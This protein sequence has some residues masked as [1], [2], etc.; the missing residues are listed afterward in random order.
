M[1]SKKTPLS[2]ISF[3]FF[4]LLFSLSSLSFASTNLTDAEFKGI[5]VSNWK[6]GYCLLNTC[7]DALYR[8]HVK[9]IEILVD[10]NL[11]TE[12]RAGVTKHEYYK[13]VESNLDAFRKQNGRL[14]GRIL[15]HVINS[16]AI[17][18]KSNTAD[19]TNN[20]HILLT[21]LYIFCCLFFLWSLPKMVDFLY[22]QSVLLL[23]GA[24]R[25]IVSQLANAESVISEQHEAKEGLDVNNNVA[26]E[27]HSK[28][29]D[30]DNIVN[31]LPLGLK[32]KELDRLKKHP[33]ERA[34]LNKKRV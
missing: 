17:K 7:N 28:E 11:T 18:S 31:A 23:E 19:D 32:Q 29:T 12:S 13:L 22:S 6:S 14:D 1:R 25:S 24:E 5:Y 30:S 10:K 33:F 8:H 9:M 20:I 2:F 21:P 27:E 26:K 15:P 16:T 3:F 34:F 4:S